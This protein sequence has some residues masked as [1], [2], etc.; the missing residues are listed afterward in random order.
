[1]AGDLWVFAKADCVGHVSDKQTDWVTASQDY[2]CALKRWLGPLQH[3]HRRGCFS[4]DILIANI[5]RP[6][7]SVLIHLLGR[8]KKKASRGHAANRPRTKSA[9]LRVQWKV[10]G[11][12]PTRALRSTKQF[13]FEIPGSGFK[14]K[15]DGTFSVAATQLLQ[16][17]NSPD[18]WSFFFWKKKWPSCNPDFDSART[19]RFL[20]RLLKKVKPDLDHWGYY[21]SPRGEILQ[22]ARLFSHV[23][24]NTWTDCLNRQ[25]LICRCF[26]ASICPLFSSWCFRRSW[27]WT[28][29]FLSCLD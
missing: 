9:P 28:G 29:G 15:S 14:S 22:L 5:E 11:D 18:P 2:P 19:C 23:L 27:S 24:T 8:F 17:Q 16:L 4:L 1:M 20:S 25:D 12:A 6:Y 7:P 21:W 3:Y 26:S 10:R 13:L